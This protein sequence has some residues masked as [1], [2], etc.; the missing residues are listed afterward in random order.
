MSPFIHVIILPMDQESTVAMQNISDRIQRPYKG[1]TRIVPED[2]FVFVHCLVDNNRFPGVVREPFSH[3]VRIVSRNPLW[4]FEHQLWV[5]P[6]LLD[7]FDLVWIH[8]K[9]VDNNREI[10]RPI[11]GRSDQV[12]ESMKVCLTRSRH[13]HQVVF[14]RHWFRLT[15]FW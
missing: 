3:V 6:L 10:G 4:P 15:R 7:R 2:G 1:G 9:V 13:Q 12:F 5:G 8:P 11:Q 14:S